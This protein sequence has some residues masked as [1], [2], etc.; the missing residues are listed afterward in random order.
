MTMN[1]SP[2][3]YLYTLSLILLLSACEE[4]FTPPEINAEQQ[5]VVEG[6]IEGGERPTPPYVILTRSFSFFSELTTDQLN[7][8]FVRDAEVVVSNSEISVTL[9][10]VCLEDIPE[11]FLEQVGDF[12]GTDPDS[13]GFNICVYIDLSGQ[14]EGEVGETYEL[15]VK[16]ADKTLR[17]TTTIPPLVSLDSLWFV[18]PPGEPSD[19]LAELR[20]VL[21]DPAGVPNY[22]RYFTATDDGPYL[23]PFTTIT[24]D[25]LFDGQRFELPLNK[26]EEPGED[27]DPVTFGLF[28]LGTDAS[29]KWMNIDQEHFDFWNTLEFSRANQGPFS[30]YTRVDHNIE[31]GIGIWGGIA[32]SYYDLEVEL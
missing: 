25:L 21:D 19:T 15:T 31:G 13:I 11:P 8:A 17:S 20:V 24:D 10:E 3:V 32:A 2:L 5:I 23:R 7:D 26:A 18:P 14:M 1:S 4:E 30:S 9:T 22:Y 27:F 29:I 16:A 12:L 6:Y 28:K